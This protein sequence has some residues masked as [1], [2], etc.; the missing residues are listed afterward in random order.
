[1]KNCFAATAIYLLLA[2]PAFAELL[3]VAESEELRGQ[4]IAV[5][6]AFENGN[7][8]ALI[9]HTHPSLYA[10]TGGRDAFAEMT[11]QALVQLRET[12]IKFLHAEVGTPTPIYPA[13][14]EEVCFVPRVS[15]MEIQGKKARS[16]TFMIA[17]R[18]IGGK[19]WKFLD[20]AGLR[21]HPDLLYKLL[22][23]LERGIVLPPNNLELL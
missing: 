11:L 16:T 1:M 19:E 23:K 9:E 7:A 12:G 14:D 8:E 10:L 18:P 21:K 5:T 6:T 2:T 22:P 4:I 15:V 20:G 3:S 17:I 13:G